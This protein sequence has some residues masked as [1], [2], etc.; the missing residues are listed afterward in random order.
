MDL[1]VVPDFSDAQIKA[2][3]DISRALQFSLLGLAAQDDL[4]IEE[5]DEPPEERMEINI[6]DRQYLFGGT[7]KWNSRE[8]RRGLC[9]SLPHGQPVLIPKAVAA[10]RDT[11]SGRRA[12]KPPSAPMSSFSLTPRLQ[13]MGGFSY[14][15]DRSRRSHLIPWRL[16]RHRPDG[17]PLRQKRMDAGLSSGKRAFYLQASTVLLPA[18]RRRES[19][20][21]VSNI[22]AGSWPAPGWASSCD[23]W[24]GARPI[25]RTASIY[26][27]P[28]TF[29][30]D[31]YRTNTTLRFLKARHAVFGI[32]SSSECRSRSRPKFTTKLIPLSRGQRQS[33]SDAGQ[34]RRKRRPDLLR[35]AL[36]Q[37]RTGFARGFELSAQSPQAGRWSWFIDYSYSVVKYKALDGILRN[38]DFDFGH[39]LNAVAAYRPPRGLDFSLKWRLTGGQPYTPFDIGCPPEK[40]DLFRPDPD[41]HPPL[42]GLSSPGRPGRENLR[43]QKMAS[44]R[45]HRPPELYNRKNVYYKFWD[46]G[47]A[48]TV[49]YLPLIPFIGLQASF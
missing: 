44:G 15:K 33:L 45:L 26:Q 18:G 29:W 1:T 47:E 48:R 43:L 4:D 32:E 22:S 40:R 38:G 7:L 30:L 41:Q 20:S 10:R 37:R 31:S 16:Y 25:F 6:G 27:S 2:V 8:V 21:T 19:A 46:D 9:D 24:K 39:L 28:E 13:L 34:S 49:Y 35:L 3:Y 5:S 14:Q 12:R 42:P 11:R 17:F 36:A 23:L